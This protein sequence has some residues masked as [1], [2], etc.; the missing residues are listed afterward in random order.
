MKCWNPALNAQGSRVIIVRVQGTSENI[1]SSSVEDIRKKES[2]VSKK[3]QRII[4]IHE[5]TE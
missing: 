1:C 5:R 3:L 2:W 4:G